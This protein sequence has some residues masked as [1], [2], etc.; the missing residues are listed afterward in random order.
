MIVR[1]RIRF[2]TTAT[3]GEDKQSVFW[4][5]A[6]ECDGW[7]AEMI[8]VHAVMI[9]KLWGGDI[10]TWGISKHDGSQWVSEIK[11][12]N[13]LMTRESLVRDITADVAILAG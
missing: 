3:L 12:D 10:L 5:D 1:Y 4:Q 7:N 11:H 6:D 9:C 8:E 2:Y 13:Y